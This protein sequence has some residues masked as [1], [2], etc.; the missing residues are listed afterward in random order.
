MDSLQPDARGDARRLALDDG[1]SGWL[2]PNEVAG[3]LDNLQ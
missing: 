1:A 3:R 2:D